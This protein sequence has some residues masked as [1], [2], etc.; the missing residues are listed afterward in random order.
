M[1]K[2]KNKK[3][4]RTLSPEHIKKMQEGRKKAKVRREREAKLKERGFN[5][6]IDKGKF[7]KMLDKLKR[8]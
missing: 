2:K 4:K 1:A 6:D 5:K 7:K 8:K 3:K